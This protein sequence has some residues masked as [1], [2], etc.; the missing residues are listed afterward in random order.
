MYLIWAGLNYS[1]L[2]N[3]TSSNLEENFILSIIFFILSGLVATIWIKI[4]IN[5]NN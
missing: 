2:C 4:A 5:E 1:L 3:L